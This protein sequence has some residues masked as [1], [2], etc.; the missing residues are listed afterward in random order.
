MFM[1]GGGDQPD[2]DKNI[3]RIQLALNT[4]VNKTS[5]MFPY[6]VNLEREPV[7]VKIKYARM[8][9]GESRANMS[10]YQIVLCYDSCQ[11]QC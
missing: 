6:F 2:W 1:E 5:E 3:S 11:N 9:T 4:T 8:V 10:P 7:M